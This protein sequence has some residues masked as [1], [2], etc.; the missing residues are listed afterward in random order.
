MHRQGHRRRLGSGFEALE[1][2]TMLSASLDLTQSDLLQP[3]SNAQVNGVKVGS[4]ATAKMASEWSYSLVGNTM[5]ATVQPSA[6]LALM[7][8]GTDVDAAFR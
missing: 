6:G 7:G 2:R 1:S 5:D 3:F 4:P 8:G